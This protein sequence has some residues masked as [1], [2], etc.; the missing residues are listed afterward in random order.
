[1]NMTYQLSLVNHRYLPFLYVSTAKSVAY[2]VV[3][4]FFNFFGPKPRSRP[5]SLVFALL[6]ALLVVLCYGVRVIY[7][8]NHEFVILGIDVLAVQKVGSA[9]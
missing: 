4:F 3:G 9:L 8:E 1:M 7:R 6:G 5:T 2:A